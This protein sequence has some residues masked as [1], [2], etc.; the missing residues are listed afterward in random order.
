MSDYYPD[1]AE[2]LPLFRKTDP[3]TSKAAASKSRAA[4]TG[5]AAAVLQALRRGPA[6]QTEIGQRCGLLPHQANKRLA[7]LR[8]LGLAEP[9][10][11]ACR[12]PGGYLEREWRAKDGGQ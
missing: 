9:T 7:D 8:R 12:N 6:G 4:R 11:E 10:G 3:P 5:Q 1:V 2:V